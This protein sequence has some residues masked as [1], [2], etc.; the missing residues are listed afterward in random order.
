MRH[1]LSAL[2]LL[3]LAGEA[4][5]APLLRSTD[6]IANATRSGFNGFERSVAFPGTDPSH[7]EGGITATAVAGTVWTGFVSWGGEGNRAWY[8]DHGSF[9]FTRIT[10]EDGRDFQD[11]GLLIGHGNAG[12]FARYLYDVRLNG[13]L[14]LFGLLDGTRG[15]YLGFSG[16]G[17]DEIRVIG[18]GID[19]AAGLLGQLEVGGGVFQAVAIDSI[20]V[21][22]TA[23]PGPAALA[24]FGLGL[25]GLLL[26]RR[27]A[28]AARS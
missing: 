24:L 18:A 5:A 26:A 21:R 19:F 23:V 9:G 13:A 2:L 20:E 7:T 4:A 1:L 28:R 14:V 8:H 15:Q 25:T 3:V 17:F 22:F 27:D 12:G 16:G 11:V 6:F 10:M